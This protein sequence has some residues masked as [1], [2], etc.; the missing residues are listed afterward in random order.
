VRQWLRAS[1][2]GAI[3]ALT[4]SISACG[5]VTGGPWGP[6]AVEGP[7]DGGATAALG[8]GELEI[9]DACVRIEGRDALLVWPS[10]RTSWDAD[11]Q[12]ILFED[13]DNGRGQMELTNGT[14]VALGGAGSRDF[15][16]RR[17]VDWVNPPSE[18][19]RADVRYY[20]HDVDLP[21]DLRS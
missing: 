14:R 17:E 13:A 21:A 6:L 18:E 3:V 2:F 20:I 15:G 7:I 10:D 16:P 1:M 4:M 8:G 12:T 9:G 5:W 11:S 19:C